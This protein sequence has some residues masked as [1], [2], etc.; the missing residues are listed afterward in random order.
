MGV[1]FVLAVYD[2]PGRESH[3]A[4]GEARGREARLIR[5]IRSAPQFRMVVF[6]D[7]N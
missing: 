6:S 4:G 1:I 7:F 5:L 2:V 3:H